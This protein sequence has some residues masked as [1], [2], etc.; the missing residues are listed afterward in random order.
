MF[1]IPG[2]TIMFNPVIQK[3]KIEVRKVRGHD[4]HVSIL[5]ADYR[6]SIF[7]Y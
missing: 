1:Q 2:F 3:I 7:F 4:N 6:N 5:A